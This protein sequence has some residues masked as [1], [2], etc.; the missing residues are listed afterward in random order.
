VLI[1]GAELHVGNGELVPGGMILI[2]NG[3]ITAVGQDI[4]VPDGV[5]VLNLP[6]AILTPGLIDANA[7]LEP[8]NI[9]VEEPR[10]AANILHHLFCPRHKD[11]PV[12][13][14]CGS[15]CPLAEEHV[16]GEPCT[17]CGF[18]NANPNLAL[19]TTV[20]SNIAEHS[21]EVIPH[22]R[23]LDAVNF[24]S[25]DFDRLLTDGVTTVF[26]S[27]DSGAVISSRGA[28]VRTS[29]PAADRVLRPEDA[30]T[31]VMGSD[32]FAR[33]RRNNLPFQQNVTFHS[34][35]PTTRMGVTWVFRKAM[36]ETLA[37]NEDREIGGADTPSD[38]AMA[39]LRRVLLKEIPLRIQ[40]RMQHDILSAIRLAGEFGLPFTL[41]EATEAHLALKEIKAAQ[42]PVIFGP[43]YESPQGFRAYSGE[44]GR[45]RLRT[46]RALL[47]EGI[48]TALSANDLRDEGGLSRQAM[49]AVRFGA[50]ED[51][52]MP[53]VTAT[54]AKLLGLEDQL[55]T[56]EVGKRGDVVAWSGAPFDSTSRPLVVVMDGYVVLDRRDGARGTRWTEPANG[57]T[58][59]S[60]RLETGIRAPL[61]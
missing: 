3:R 29:G 9:M 27:P 40:A 14:C 56:L 17:R 44:T 59:A 41:V 51:R 42:T 46:F 32:P 47:D 36:Y 25:P 18:P 52:I 35:R 8:S 58:S 50:G 23:I 43:V 33:G 55:G 10:T 54:P 21:S 26:V 53:T 30:V 38:E 31:A 22:T 61:P 48:P 2:Q 15:T 24:R 7:A 19:G 20:W 11:H 28:V 60:M 6:T 37:R 5:T 57:K 49:Y 39:V 4:A 1:T 34:R 13:G 16:T 45:S 12:L